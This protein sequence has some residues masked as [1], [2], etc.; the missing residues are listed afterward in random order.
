MDTLAFKA[1]YEL[2]DAADKAISSA[3]PDI[4]SY[5]G[6]IASGDQFVHT[7]ARKTEIVQEFAALCCEMEGA[8]IG[9]VCHLNHIPF[10]VMRTISDNADEESRVDYPKFEK[11]TAHDNARIIEHMLVTL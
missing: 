2:I 9:Q 3:R 8:A 5:M 4:H 6:R 11:Q 1:S 10:V 7:R